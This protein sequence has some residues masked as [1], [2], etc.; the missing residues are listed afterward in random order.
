VTKTRK[1]PGHTQNVSLCDIGYCSVG[2]DEGWEGCGEG[3]N[4]TQHDA[5]GLPTIDTAS[6]PDT[7]GMVSDIH[8]LGLAA[9]WY[10][11]GCKCGERTELLQNYEGDIKDL[12]AF[13]FDG[14]KIDGC[15]HQRNQTLYAALMR[16]SGKNYT[17]ENCHWGDCTDSDDSSCPTSTWCPFNWYRTSGDINSSPSSWLANLQTTTKF[18]NLSAPLSVPGCWAYPD[19]LE[20]GRVTQPTD[21]AFYSWN[22]AHFGAWCIVSAP[23]I[24]GLELTDAKLAPIIDIITNEEAIHINQAWAGHPGRLAES[25][26]APPAPYSPTGVTIPSNGAGDF[27]LADG[28]SI[29][30]GAGHIDSRTSGAASIRTG[31]PGQTSL[32]QIGTGLLAPGHAIDSVSLSFRYLA[33]YTIPNKQASVVEIVLVTRDTATVR[34]T[35][36]TSPPLGNYSWDR[37]TGFGPPIAVHATGLNVPNDEVLVLALRVVNHERNLQIPVDDLADGFGVKVTWAASAVEASALT[38]SASAPPTANEQHSSDVQ[39]AT[40]A[41]HHHLAAPAHASHEAGAAGGQRDEALPSYITKHTVGS[42]AGVA[43]QGQVWTKPLP[44]GGAAVLLI[45]SSPQQLSH[46]LNLTKLAIPPSPH[47]YTV[48]DIWARSFLAPTTP[49]HPLMPVTVPAFDSVFLRFNPHTAA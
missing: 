39:K 15:G 11:N 37:F 23:L 20:V 33:G 46:S 12:H 5:S 16:A 48:R 40:P 9:G 14:V 28:A 32:I 44:G 27:S 1:V 22:R 24:L 47:G 45:N 21:G 19:M 17:I 13:G 18:Q 31:G 49:D 43:G 42:D 8:G 3:V 35:L 7:G 41:H 38:P 6:F 36:F 29:T 4:G 10:L 2:V 30:S 34:A 25:V 26:Y